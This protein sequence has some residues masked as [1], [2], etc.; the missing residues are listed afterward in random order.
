MSVRSVNLT[1]GI[2][3]PESIE[4]RGHPEGS[5]CS[6]LC[7]GMNPSCEE[8]V[9]AERQLSRLGGFGRY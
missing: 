9:L 7:F 1:D 4:Q 6:S 8:A 3:D 2:P 5:R